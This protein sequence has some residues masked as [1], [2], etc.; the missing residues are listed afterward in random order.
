MVLTYRVS[1]PKA[2]FI[3]WSTRCGLI[4]VASKLVL[5]HIV[6]RSSAE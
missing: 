2:R 3:S 5:R 4:G 1:G 6:R